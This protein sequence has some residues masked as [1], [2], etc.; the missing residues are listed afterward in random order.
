MLRQIF[1]FIFLNLSFTSLLLAQWEEVNKGLFGGSL[2][3]MT[4]DP[5]TN[6]FYAGTCSGVFI[7]KDQGLTWEEKNQGFPWINYVWDILIIGDKI[8]ATVSDQGIY[9]SEDKGDSW[10]LISEMKTSSFAG[11]SDYL[12]ANVGN[13]VY[14]SSDSGHSWEEIYHHYS[15]AIEIVDSTII[16]GTTEGVIL[17]MDF[18][19]SWSKGAGLNSWVRSLAVIGSTFYAGTLEGLYMSTDHGSNWTSVIMPFE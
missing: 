2:L 8:F 16:F 13:K 15:S 18:G 5:T 17:S 10:K 19:Q 12:F 4:E 3:T 11:N 7:S 1:L 6:I 14:R 9:L